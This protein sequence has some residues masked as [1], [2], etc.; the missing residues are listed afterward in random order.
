VRAEFKL[1]TAQT[2]KVTVS[3]VGPILAHESFLGK[4]RKDGYITVP[5]IVVELLRRDKPSLET[6]IMEVTLEPA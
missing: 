4:M 3:V 2:L 5:P 6:Y 1:E